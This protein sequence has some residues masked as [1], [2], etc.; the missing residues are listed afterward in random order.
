[1]KSQY[2]RMLEDGE[3]AWTGLALNVEQAEEKCF[4]DEDPSPMI[5]YTLQRWNGKKW[6]T[7]YENAKLE[8]D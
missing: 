2:Y 5:N 1:M 8:Q 6:I 3:T 4:Q 7:V